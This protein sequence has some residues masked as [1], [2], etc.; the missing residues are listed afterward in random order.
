MDIHSFFE[1]TFNTSSLRYAFW[2][3]FFILMLISFVKYYMAKHPDPNDWTHYLLE[4]PVDVIALLL[5]VMIT[6]VNVS[7]LHVE[8]LI[9]IVTLLIC[10]IC[11]FLRRLSIKALSRDKFYYGMWLYPAIEIMLSCSWVYLLVKSL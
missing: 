3:S 6:A 7:T 10:V 5:T 8:I 11:C 9:F 4:F 1:S 2:I